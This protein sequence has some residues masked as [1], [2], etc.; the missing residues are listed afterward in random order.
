MANV[1]TV[2]TPYWIKGV[3]FQGN[4]SDVMAVFN[5]DCGKVKLFWVL[6]M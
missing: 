3:D 5:P 1:A 2:K 6:V 4:I